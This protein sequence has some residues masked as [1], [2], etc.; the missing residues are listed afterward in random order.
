VR[1]PFVV[2]V[3]EADMALELWGVEITPR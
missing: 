2:T 1:G 3:N